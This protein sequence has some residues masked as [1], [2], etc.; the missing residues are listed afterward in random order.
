MEK[1]T[2]TKR[3]GVN[4]MLL[5]GVLLLLIAATLILGCAGFTQPTNQI[6]PDDAVSNLVSWA[7]FVGIEKVPKILEKPFADTVTFWIGVILILVPVVIW[8]WRRF[9]RDSGKRILRRR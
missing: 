7:R 6:P 1:M 4:W 3:N 2:K 9:V 5:L 8:G